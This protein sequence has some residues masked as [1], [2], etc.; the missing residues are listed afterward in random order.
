MSTLEQINYI[1]NKYE[2]LE[3][4][5]D[6]FWFKPNI[7]PE[8][9]YIPVCKQCISDYE[10]FKLMNI[11][12]SMEVEIKHPSSCLW[13]DWFSKKIKLVCPSAKIVKKRN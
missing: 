9:G 8:K 10:K 12:D 1:K 4:N 7:D 2:E 6:E 5:D 11:R 3:I 13:Y